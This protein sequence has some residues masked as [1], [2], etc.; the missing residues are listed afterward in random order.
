MSI[1]NTFNL[2]YLLIQ[3]VRERQLVSCPRIQHNVP[4][5]GS[6]QDSNNEATVT[7]TTD[8]CT[9]VYFYVVLFL[10]RC[11]VAMKTKSRLHDS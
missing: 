4:G 9:I 10:C 3:L 7:L 11:L 1:D 8:I 2:S 6:N 5:Q